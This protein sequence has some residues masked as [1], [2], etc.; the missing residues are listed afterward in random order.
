MAIRQYIGA[1]YVP[2]FTGLYDATQI[3]EA[4]DVV[5]N[6][7]GTSYI[8]KKTV[9][10]GT[11]LTDRDYWFLYGA[12]SGAIINLQDQLDAL[13]IRIDSLEFANS[14]RFIFQGDSYDDIGDGW[15]NPVCSIL[16]IT[17]YED[18]SYYGEGFTTTHSFKDRLLEASITN[19]ETVTDIV[20]C[21]GANDRLGMSN[22]VNAIAA[23]KTAAYGA[24]PNL[25]NIYIGC[26]G[27]RCNTAIY[28]RESSQVASRYK[29]GCA[30][31]GL[32]YLRGTDYLLMYPTFWATTGDTNHP[33]ANGV[34]FMARGIAEALLTGSVDVQYMYTQTIPW[35]DT[36]TWFTPTGTGIKFE[37]SFHNGVC[38][39]NIS[40]PTI[41]ITTGS[42]S[43]RDIA[44]NDAGFNIFALP[45]KP[46]MLSYGFQ[47][48]TAFCPITFE[49]DGSDM[50]TIKA[51]TLM[52]TTGNTIVQEMRGRFNIQ[53]DI[54]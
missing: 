31:N 36:P 8:A 22:I 37:T 6:G 4:L 1:R 30:A 25:R 2:R 42:V 18:I 38:E 44:Y 16:G 40:V 11:P 3:Y 19:P 10:A 52:N 33:Q 5:D 24:F 28:V 39:V 48:D 20:V 53:N 13:D 46:I 14:R 12:S 9:P 47:G 7:S 54:F 43:K 27:F 23:Y 50:R 41:N 35:I 26:V 29:E 32:H 15:I 45:T 34:A 17:N 21:G 49:T 51:Y